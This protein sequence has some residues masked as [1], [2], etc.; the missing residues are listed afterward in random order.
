M[1]SHRPT[2]KTRIMIRGI[3]TDPD[4]GYDLSACM[5]LQ[6]AAECL[7]EAKAGNKEKARTLMRLMVRQAASAA[8]RRD[9]HLAAL[10]VEVPKSE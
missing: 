3:A 8:K 4:T 7:L 10:S 9:E 1:A 2:L 5:A 6:Y